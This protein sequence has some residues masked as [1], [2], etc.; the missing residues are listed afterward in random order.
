MHSFF[1]VYVYIHPK[2]RHRECLCSFIYGVLQTDCYGQIVLICLEVIFTGRNEVL[3]KVIFLHVCVILF[4]GRGTWPPG[5]GRYPPGPDHPPW[6]QT[7][8]GT[9]PLP[10]G[11]SCDLSHHAFDVTCMLS[12]HQ[13]SFNTRA[14]AYIVWPRCMLG[15]TTPPP[16][17]QNDRQV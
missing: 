17:E 9:R 15:Y 10:R 4:T 6:D 1:L 7:P 14:A 11:V 16:C 12:Q 13:L 5:P 8:P 3:A 2:N